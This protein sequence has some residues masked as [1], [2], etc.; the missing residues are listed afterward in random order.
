[1]ANEI[2]VKTKLFNKSKL[3]A[4]FMVRSKCHECD[5]F[6]SGIVSRVGCQ[7]M[8]LLLTKRRFTS[9]A[10]KSR[11]QIVREL[12]NEVPGNFLEGVKNYINRFKFA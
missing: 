6:G 9:M 11:S 3:N 1:M 2:L 8:R 10:E 12:G 5:G 4:Q 7:P